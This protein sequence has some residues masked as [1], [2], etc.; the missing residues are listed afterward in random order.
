MTGLYVHIPFCRKKCHYCNY[1][2]TTRNASGFRSQVLHSIKCE[3]E[4][5][6]ETYGRLEFDTL[7]LGGGTPSVLKNDEM[8]VLFLA[9]KSAFVIRPLAEIT[10][11]VN[12]GD[13]SEDKF[14]AYLALGINRISLGV[15][16]FNDRLLKHM[17][18]MH[19]SRE[20]EATFRSL[21]KMGFKNISVD[22]ILRLPGQTLHDWRIAKVP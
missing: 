14:K 4:H 7:Y 18:R 12:P 13:M 5:A 21:R 1:I 19:D 6:R 9:L 15:Q 8:N 11:E 3:I 17:G 16:S 2:I 10:C 22:L 20:A